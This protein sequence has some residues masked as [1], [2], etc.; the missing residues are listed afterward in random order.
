MALYW[1]LLQVVGSKRCL[2]MSDL[3][4]DWLVQDQ[5]PFYTAERVPLVP[6]QWMLSGFVGFFCMLTSHQNEV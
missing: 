6:E 1:G 2:E 5:L 3:D 4:P